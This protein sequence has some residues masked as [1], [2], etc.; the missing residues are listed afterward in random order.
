MKMNGLIIKNR[1]IDLKNK[2][3]FHIVIG[4]FM[5][6]FVSFFGSIFIV[7]LLTKSDYGI[8]S[9]YENFTSYFTIFAGYGLSSGILR[10]V[11]LNDEL[12]EKKSCFFYA[13]KYGTYWNIILVVCGLFILFIYPHPNAFTN[14]F[15]IALVLMLCIP[16]VFLYNSGLSTLRALFDNK[17]YAIIT[18]FTAFILIFARLLGAAI[19]G[20]DLTTVSR[21]IA[22][23][24]CATSCVIFLQKKYFANQLVKPLNLKNIKALNVYSMQMMLTDGLWTIF[25]LNDL[26]L[27]GQ[28]TGSENIVADYK[29]AYVIPANLSILTAAVGIFVA[30]YFTKNEKEQ[31]VEWIRSKFVVVL[32]VTAIVIGFFAILCFILA[33]PL[34]LLLYGEAYMSAITIMRILILASFF[35]NGIRASIANILSAVGNQ[36]H[37]L[38]VA[39]GGIIVQIVLN[40][41]LIPQYG[42]IGV[43]FSSFIVYLLM[44]TALGIIFW[45][46]YFRII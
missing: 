20:L 9:Y 10:Y 19:G 45:Y 33:K 1:I 13:I 43:A 24:V 8:L 17:S 44:S 42:S 31:N 12:S 32:K 23:I 14:H 2:G 26:F 41:I 4:S 3:A 21:F 35:N 28:L 5:T 6:K 27:L 22:E 18:L 37:N 15:L 7:R 29:V 30:P 36:K 11:V 39:T 16:F 25:M 40:V 34:I 46:K 38:L